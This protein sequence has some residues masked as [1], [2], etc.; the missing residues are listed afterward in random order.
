MKYIAIDG[1]AAGKAFE[2]W[3]GR[4]ILE[5]PCCDAPEVTLNA[6]SH[7]LP[8]DRNLS[9]YREVYFLQHVELVEEGLLRRFTF[10][11]TARRKLPCFTVLDK[12]T[13]LAL[14]DDVRVAGTLTLASG[15]R[16]R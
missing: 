4:D 11:T 14:V 1:K 13:S 10:W 12:L 8:L 16:S 7:E 3:Q 15:R 9:Y 6:M 5:V 2:P